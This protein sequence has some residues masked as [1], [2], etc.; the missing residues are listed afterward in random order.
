VDVSAPPG[1]PGLLVRLL[2]AGSSF[3]RQ[4][5]DAWDT[6]LRSYV[7][8]LIPPEQAPA[9]ANPWLVLLA[10][11][12]ADDADCGPE[13]ADTLL[14]RPVIQQA[15]HAQLLWDRETYL[16]NVLF[17]CAA[18]A[19]GLPVALTSQCTTVVCLS[20]R[21]PPT[22][23]VFL[24]AGGGRYDVFGRSRNEYRRS[25]F[26]ALRGPV[27]ITLRPVGPASPPL[28]S[29]AH[30]TGRTFPDGPTAYRA[31]NAELWAEFRVDHGV[32]RVQTD[33]ATTA[34][35]LA[36][37]VEHPDSPVRRLL[38]D[39]QV[40][41]TFLT[42]KR[43]VVAAGDNLAVNRA[44]PDWF[45]LRERTRLVPVVRNGDGYAVEHDGSPPPLDLEDPAEVA[46]ALRAGNLHGD[47]VLAYLVR[48]M[49]PGAVAVGGSVQQD[50]T[51]MYRRMIA[52]TQALTPFLEPAELAT[53]LDP[54]LSRLGGAPLLETPPEQAAVWDGLGAGW[55][56]ADL[57]EAQ[58][59][60]PVGETAGS[61]DCAWFY[62]KNIRAA[63]DRHAATT[64]A[65]Q[66]ADR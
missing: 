47:R 64:A 48:S 52:E 18:S 23:P 20:R 10:E 21:T 33:E 14:R 1:A 11:A 37:H 66:G 6:P 46:A 7:R 39:P 28:R 12:V 24:A 53:A 16:N 15:D 17:H 42:V 35:A 4:L 2:A 32:R 45:W 27:E 65:A 38:F 43:R 25:A 5:A 19:E 55:D 44:Q 61:L 50:Y 63:Q 41:D 36:R 59:D 31:L 13:A 57:V 49:L 30:L 9:A 26:C 54:A 34:E 60:R 56:P 29:A 8:S 62:D 58:L 51:A 40:R 22:G 3:G